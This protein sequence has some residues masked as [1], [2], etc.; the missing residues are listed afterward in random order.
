MV[1]KTETKDQA[2][3]LVDETLMSF[4]EL[5]QGGDEAAS[6]QSEL[7]QVLPESMSKR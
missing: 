4:E 1:A 6:G 5:L 7:C 2:E 3:M